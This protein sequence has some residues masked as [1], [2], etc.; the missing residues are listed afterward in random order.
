M[1]EQEKE[2]FVQQ[3]RTSKADEIGIGRE[4][5][6]PYREHLDP[7]SLIW[8]AV[9]ESGQATTLVVKSP[10]ALALRVG[11]QVTDIP[12]NSEIRFFSPSNPDQVVRF[13]TGQEIKDTLARNIASQK[14]KIISNLFWSPVIEGDSV[15]IEIYLPAGADKDEL[16]LSIPLA[17]HLFSSVLNHTEKRL[18]DIGE[19]DYCE[20][21]VNC[22]SA[23]WGEEAHAI[24]KII[25]T[26]SGSGK[27]FACSGSLIVD[28]DTTT[29]EPYFLT[30]NHC[31]SSQNV[32]S[33]LN[34]Y[35]FFE[36]DK[37][38]G[39]PP[40]S[41]QHLT[42]GAQMLAHGIDTDFSFL[43]LSD[44]PPAGTV[45]LGWSTGAVSVNDDVTTIH[46]PMGDLKKISF[47]DVDYLLNNDISVIWS[48]GVTEGGSSGAPLLIN[49]GHYI[50]GQLRG[51]SSS[52]LSSTSPDLFGR[53]DLTISN[54]KQWLLKPTLLV[55]VNGS[56]GVN[57]LPP[58]RTCI[59]ECTEFY[60]LDTSVTLTALPSSGS[61]FTGWSG[62]CT[63][64]ETTCNLSMNTDKGVTASFKKPILTV[65]KLGAGTGTIT[66]APPG[67]D[68]G[69]DCSESYASGTAV[70]LTASPAAGSSFVNWSGGCTNTTNTC[71]LTMTADQSVGANFVPVLGQPHS[72][73]QQNW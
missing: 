30:A 45:F 35:W 72:Y 20:I 66:S 14:T 64:M 51:G 25:Y 44:K 70:T 38:N 1:S 32:A 16:Q 58:G 36:T 47:G 33:T 9:N 54:I 21:D 7:L 73:G 63:G 71:S 22:Y 49:N 41:V 37:C 10:G 69:A 52:C 13:V 28:Q 59:T 29:D 68:C 11:L 31:I 27:T 2:S 43:K 19:S 61:Y 62:D 55:T 53:F 56:G 65:N 46:H 57:L 3:R 18:S 42:G 40:T 17:S 67:I 8:S 34:T 6:L 5:P 60:N 15:G 39:V 24:A 4:I 12:A 23:I 26:D 48:A 50:V